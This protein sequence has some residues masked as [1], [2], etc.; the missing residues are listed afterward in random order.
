M[1]VGEI[2]EVAK[3]LTIP[4]KDQYGLAMKPASDQEL[5]QHCICIWW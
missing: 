3:Q 2:R 5:V 4:E 1:D